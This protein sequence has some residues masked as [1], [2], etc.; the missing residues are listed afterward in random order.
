MTPHFPHHRVSALSRFFLFTLL[1]F[2]S[3]GSRS[4][5]PSITYTYTC[6]RAFHLGLIADLTR[7]FLCLTQSSLPL[8]CP[9]PKNK[10][11]HTQKK[12]EKESS[13]SHTILHFTWNTLSLPHLPCPCPLGL[14]CLCPLHALPSKQ[15][16]GT[17][18]RN[19]HAPCHCR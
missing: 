14:L 17:G 9:L 6:L 1:I 19:S 8:P 7:D 4:P 13:F 18:W 3:F 16:E 10:E 5:L 11:G 12:K 2:A 15:W